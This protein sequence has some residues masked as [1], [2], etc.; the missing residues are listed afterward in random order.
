[1]SLRN[2]PT[3][4]FVGAGIFILWLVTAFCG[5]LLM[6]TDPNALNFEALLQ[7]P[8]INH[9][10]GTDHLGRDILTRVVYAGRIDIWMG[11]AGVLPALIIGTLF[12]LMAGYFGG[13]VE[14][15]LMRVTD[16]TQA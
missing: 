5:P 14:A 1:M 4:L 6:G 16:V 11:F 13:V 10:F 12:G 8:N 3:T 9:L 2:L 7:R 15:V